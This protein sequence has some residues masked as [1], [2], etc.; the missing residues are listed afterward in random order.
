MSELGYRMVDAIRCA[1]AYY[2]TS[3]AKEAIIIRLR[4]LHLSNLQIVTR[5]KVETWQQQGNERVKV[6]SV[7]QDA[8]SAIRYLDSA[9]HSVYLVAHLW[10]RLRSPSFG[11]NDTLLAAIKATKVSEAGSDRAEQSLGYFSFKQQAGQKKSFHT[12]IC[13]NFELAIK[14]MDAILLDDAARDSFEQKNVAMLKEWLEKHPRDESI[15]NLVKRTKH[16][17][18]YFTDSL[19]ES[20]LKPFTGSIEKLAA[21]SE[22]TACWSA[23][24]RTKFALLSTG[25]AALEEIIQKAKNRDAYAAKRKGKRIHDGEEDDF[26]ST[27]TKRK[28]MSPK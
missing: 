9:T 13:E 3:E 7:V 28:K 24:K 1:I 20:W 10:K 22:T 16:G 19:V 5:R 2:N 8:Q 18:E 6:V 17:S 12:R 14:E 23:A 27:L 4:L 15:Y 21:D 25:D 11:L 26:Y